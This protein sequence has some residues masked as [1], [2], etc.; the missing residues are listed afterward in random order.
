MIPRREGACEEFRLC[1]AF[2]VIVGEK[3][4]RLDFINVQDQCGRITTHF[5]TTAVKPRTV[6]LDDK[7]ALES[8]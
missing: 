1:S 5:T 3:D 7:W 2:G 4:M 6:D 8:V